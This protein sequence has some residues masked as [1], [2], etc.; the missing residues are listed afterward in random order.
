MRCQKTGDEKMKFHLSLKNPKLDSSRCRA[1]SLDV[2][3]ERLLK[4]TLNERCLSL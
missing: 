2:S 4:E 1:V 3:L